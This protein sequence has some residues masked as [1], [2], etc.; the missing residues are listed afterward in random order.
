MG[1]REDDVPRGTS[2]LIFSSGDMKLAAPGP[3]GDG[4]P[5]RP[6]PTKTR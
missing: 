1:M 4:Y 3:Y 2:V 6:G 5:S